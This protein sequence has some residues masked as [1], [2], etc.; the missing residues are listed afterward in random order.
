MTIKSFM[1]NWIAAI[2]EHPVMV[3]STTVLLTTTSARIERMSKRR[4]KIA[5]AS[6]PERTR[7]LSGFYPASLSRKK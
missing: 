2:A 5:L 4:R 6:E 3:R 1:D 7:T